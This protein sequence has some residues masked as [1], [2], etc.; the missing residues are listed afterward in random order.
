[1]EVRDA[2]ESDAVSAQTEILELLLLMLLRR[3]RVVV[4]RERNGGRAA[5]VEVV[6]LSH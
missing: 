5:M 4:V 1:M 6:S 3:V 2:R